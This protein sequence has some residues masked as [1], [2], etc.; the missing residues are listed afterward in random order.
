MT[1]VTKILLIA[2]AAVYGLALVAVG[3]ASLYR[4]AKIRGI[5]RRLLELN[6]A[7]ASLQRE[8]ERE[9]PEPKRIRSMWGNHG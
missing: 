5:E 1:D 8:S 6:D 7:L 2:L 3:V 4:A 9:R